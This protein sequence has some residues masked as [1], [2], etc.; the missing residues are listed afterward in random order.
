MNKKYEKLEKNM[1]ITYDE[2]NKLWIYEG[3]NELDFTPFAGKYLNRAGKGLLL[4][5]IYL[6]KVVQINKSILAIFEGNYEIYNPTKIYTEGDVV[7]YQDTFY[8]SLDDNNNKSLKDEN[9]WYP[10]K[11]KLNFFYMQ[12]QENDDVYKISIK[13]GELVTEKVTE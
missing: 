10:F 9:A 2:I 5:F 12:D 4:D 11:F 3:T 13:N 7:F 1:P 6:Q 8:I